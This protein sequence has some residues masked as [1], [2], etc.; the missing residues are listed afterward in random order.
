MDITT[1]S[2]LDLRAGAVITATLR[3]G[4]KITGQVMQQPRLAQ[5]GKP[6]IHRVRIEVRD[7]ATQLAD[8]A[9][10]M[11]MLTKGRHTVSGDRVVS[12]EAAR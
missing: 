2:L 10:V 4:R 6:G 8:S 9:G 7:T 3:S 12:I 1:R 5:V 11:T